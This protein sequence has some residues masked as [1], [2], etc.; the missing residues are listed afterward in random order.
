[1][2]KKKLKLDDLKV[3]SFVTSLDNEKSKKIQGGTNSGPMYTQVCY[4][5]C[6]GDSCVVCASVP[7]CDTCDQTCESQIETCEITC[8][9]AT[10][11]ESLCTE[12]W[13]CC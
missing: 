12:P 5:T 7:T 3:Q 10:C 9:G 11:R 6:A 1:M 2:K 13:Q 4:Y 8:Q